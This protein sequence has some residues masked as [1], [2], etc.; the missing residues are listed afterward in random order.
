MKTSSP[1]YLFHLFLTVFTYLKEV[2]TG[3]GSESPELLEWNTRPLQGL[4]LVLHNPVAPKIGGRD[5][6]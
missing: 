5:D 3:K 4:L 6:H 2:V 1:Y